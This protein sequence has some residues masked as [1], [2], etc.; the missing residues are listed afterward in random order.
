MASEAIQ[1]ETRQPEAVGR[2]PTEEAT[3]TNGAAAVDNADKN[4]DK[5]SVE[6]DT[7]DKPEAVADSSKPTS[8]MLKTKGQIN[9]KDIKANNKFD[10]S[11]LPETDDPAKIRAQVPI[12]RSPSN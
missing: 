7:N 3:A 9:Y 11:V 8:G 10:A 12:P 6:K 5:K 1:A 2:A 4:I